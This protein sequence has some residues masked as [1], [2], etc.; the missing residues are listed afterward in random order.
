MRWLE[1]WRGLPEHPTARAYAEGTQSRRGRR[2]PL[3]DLSILAID[4]ETSGMR[5]GK[6]RILSVGG[7][8]VSRGRVEVGSAFSWYVRHPDAQVTEATRV[9][10]I[11]PAD[12]AAGMPEERAL[13][14]L[15][16]RLTGAVVVGHHV[17]FDGSMLSE[18]LKRHFGVRL[19]N[20]LVDTAQLAAIAIEA[21]HRAGYPRQPPPSLEEVC[22]Y[23]GIPMMDRH[24]ALGDAF[25]A[26]TLFLLLCARL[27]RLRG[28][29]L[30]WGDLP[31]GRI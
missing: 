20:E 10:G 27:R 4:L 21:F 16:P 3:S 19:R 8:D 13:E 17:G 30:V 26:G 11:L 5:V 7:V 31:G 15:L 22:T 29:P 12:T 23:L 6:D 1:R 2:E 14:A 24:T 18:A 9:H 28:R 25:T